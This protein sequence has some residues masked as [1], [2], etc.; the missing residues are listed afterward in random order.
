[1]RVRPYGGER[2][3]SIVFLNNTVFNAE[4]GSLAISSLYPIHERKILD[5]R[6]FVSCSCRIEE[7]FRALLGVS[8]EKNKSDDIAQ[9]TL[10]AMLAKS[11]CRRYKSIMTFTR[12][13]AYLDDVC[14]S[15]PIPII[16]SGAIVAIAI[17]ITVTVSIIC[18]RR[19][20][21]AKE[22]ANYLGECSYSH[23]FSTLHTGPMSPAI[24]LSHSWD[25]AG[26][27][28][29]QPWVMAVP[30]IKTYQETELHVDYEHTEPIAG[31][32]RVFFPAEPGPLLDLQRKTHMRSSCPFNWVEYINQS[33]R[34]RLTNTQY[35]VTVLTFY[36]VVIF[37]DSIHQALALWNYY[38]SLVI[39]KCSTLIN[40]TK[41]LS[42]NFKWSMISTIPWSPCIIKSNI[43]YKGN[44]NHV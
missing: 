28:S 10:D 40:N 7:V 9:L 15:L 14:A 37:L 33:I 23:S 18:I 39:G 29:S 30:E 31:N 4:N 8:K 20:Q 44:F 1:M 12:V 42:C 16:V 43:L 38:K 13:E 34:A 35:W 11:R 3:A 19:A 26:G 41:N 24:A 2:G 5:N 17:L 36:C 32:T 22:E 21:K 27:E 25:R 6:F